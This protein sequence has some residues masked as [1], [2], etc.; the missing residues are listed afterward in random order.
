M[1][2]DC[3]YQNNTFNEINIAYYS[4]CF[5]HLP[6][7]S[8]KKPHSRNYSIHNVNIKPYNVL[9]NK[10]DVFFTFQVLK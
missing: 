7:T 6:K 10:I 9:V 3:G 8:F 5:F 2:L 1:I 4:L